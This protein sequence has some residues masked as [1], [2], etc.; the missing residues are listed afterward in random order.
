MTDH[1][2]LIRTLEDFKSTLILLDSKDDM[3]D[4][5]I[6]VRADE[7]IDMKTAKIYLD[8]CKLKKDMDIIKQVVGMASRT[9]MTPRTP[10]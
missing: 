7:L 1:H 2:D 8:L 4:R 3:R 5:L 10:P 9:R 6:K